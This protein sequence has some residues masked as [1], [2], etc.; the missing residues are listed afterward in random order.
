LEDDEAFSV[1]GFSFGGLVGLFACEVAVVYADDFCRACEVEI[2]EIRGVGD[3]DSVCVYNDDLDVTQILSVGP[4]GIAIGYEEDSCGL[5]G[6][7]QLLDAEDAARAFGYGFDDS[8]L[9]R[10]F[11]SYHPVFEV[12][13]VLC[14]MG[15]VV[16]EQL[17]S[18]AVRE[19]DYLDV[20]GFEVREGPVRYHFGPV[21]V[22]L[23]WGRHIEG[24]VHDGDVDHWLVGPEAFVEIGDW[25]S[26]AAGVYQAAVPAV[27]GPASDCFAEVV[28]SSPVESADDEVVV[29]GVEPW[30]Y[31]VEGLVGVAFAAVVDVAFGA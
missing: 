11:P 14:A 18:L 6:C 24:I 29:Q 22:A 1:I 21:P 25:F 27:E 26:E 15:F 20:F 28:D 16:Y 8:G 4:D 19:S 9:I 3:E 7:L 30:V 12:R 13:E 5:A 23:C 10:D 17:D 2:D 31:G